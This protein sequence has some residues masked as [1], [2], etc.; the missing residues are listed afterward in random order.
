MSRLLKK[1]HGY[2]SSWSPANIVSAWR[3]CFSLEMQVDWRAFSRALAK[4]GKRMAARMAMIAITTSNSMSVK[5]ERRDMGG[6]HSRSRILLPDPQG[7]P[8]TLHW[9]SGSTP[10][11]PLAPNL[12]PQPP[13]RNG[14]GESEAHTYRG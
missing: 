5:A 10:H 2:C 9:L 1:A 12:T 14:K 6:L 11:P 7:I 4:T 8:H 13:P 3:S